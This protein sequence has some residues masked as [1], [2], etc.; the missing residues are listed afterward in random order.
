MILSALKK[1]LL[2][3]NWHVAYRQLPEGSILSDR[4]TPFQIIPNTARFHAM[5]PFVFKFNHET[6]IFAE[7]YDRWLSRGTIG[8]CKWNGNGFSSWKQ[9]IVESYHLSYPFLYEDNGEVFMVPESFLNQDVHAYRAVD[10]PDKWEFSHVLARNVKYVDTTLFRQDK[11]EYA[12]AYDVESM[13]K[14]LLLFEIHDRQFNMASR[15]VISKDYSSA[16]PG[17]RV[18]NYNGDMIR[19]SQ[20]CDGAYGKAVV[21]SRINHLKSGGEF[22]EIPLCRVGVGAVVLDDDIPYCG[23]HTYNA[24]DTMEVIDLKGHCF[25]VVDY[26]GRFA[27]KIRKCGK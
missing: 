3:G 5:D 10:F 20:D 6:F 24:V 13:E 8:Y 27:G 14:Q 11:T 4:T 1:R 21:F 25:N 9:V 22:D 2:C 17:G 16:R 23:I 12:F 7:V 26:I 18:F 15:A 19:V